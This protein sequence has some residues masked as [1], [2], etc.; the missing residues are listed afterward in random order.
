M[1]RRLYLEHRE[2]M[3]QIIAT[4]LIGW[5]EAKQWLKEAIELQQEWKLDAENQAFVR[6]RAKIGTSMRRC[7]QG[8]VG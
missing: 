3:D 1:A 4:N 8:Q 6:F 5:G 7:G 2:A